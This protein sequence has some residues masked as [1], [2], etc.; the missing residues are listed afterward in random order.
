VTVA[1]ADLRSLKSSENMVFIPDDI[2][3]RDLPEWVRKPA[4]TTDGYLVALAKTHGGHLA[5]LDESIPGA[6]LIPDGTPAPISVREAAAL[7]AWTTP[8]NTGTQQDSAQWQ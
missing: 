2:P 1:R 5:T 7:P 8:L 6:V 4:H 3:E